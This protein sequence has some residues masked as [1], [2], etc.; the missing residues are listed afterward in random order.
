M[1]RVQTCI[2]I[3][4]F[5]FCSHFAKLAESIAVK[6]STGKTDESFQLKNYFPDFLWLLRDVTLIPTGV[7][8]KRV[9]PTDFLMTK[10]F[11]RSRKF[12]ESESDMVARAIMT[13]FPKITC[14][15]IQPP[16]SDPAVVQNIASRQDCLHPQFNE[17]VEQ[18]VQYLFEIVR[19]KKGVVAG[20][21]A[22]GPILAAMA[23]HYVEAVNKTDAI[24]CITDTWQ[25]AITMRCK[26]VME[27]LLKEYDQE[28]ERRIIEQG[29]PMEE[30]SQGKEDPTKPCTLFALHRSTLLQKTAALL[31]QVGHFLAAYAQSQDSSSA[32]D[33][34][35][36]C[37][38]LEI[39]AA[40]F[41]E[42][43]TEQVI[44][45]E[46][47]R[48]KVVMGGILLKYA[49]RNHSESRSSCNRLFTK[50]YGP[51]EEKMK[52]QSYTF[53]NLLKD[54]QV[55]QEKY[56]RQAVGPAKWEVYTEKRE[57]IKAQETGFKLLQGFKQ[58]AF[59]EAQKAADVKAAAVKLEE[60]VLTLQ[61]QVKND[62]EMNHK[63]IQELKE[64]HREEIEKLRKD[65]KERMER[66]R[67]RSEDFARA[68]MKQMA[69]ITNEHSK[70]VNEQ[71]D[72]MIEMMMTI[73]GQKE[74]A[75]DAQANN[76]QRMEAMMNQQAAATTAMQEFMMKSTSDRQKDFNE[77]A[78]HMKM[79]EDKKQPRAVPKPDSK[80]CPLL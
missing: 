16:S 39:G 3:P 33:K 51:I 34:D 50:L 31:E 60:S 38:E 28:M 36:L 6:D 20:K 13:F 75:L 58:K 11:C 15:T 56:Y 32:L 7:D 40:T 66:E 69:D 18:L 54:L 27:Q 25:T 63:R 41:T 52:H 2:S 29:L 9:S 8:G 44:H 68:Q 47:V 22:D 67:Q 77:L 24:P 80:F 45:G 30:D 61:M 59:D 64:H 55:L 62:A 71:S 1:N 70:Q 73:Y 79:M 37:A 12:K 46:L 53:E 48:K 42:E 23:T 57:Y 26:K 65:E 76:M 4:L 78:S 35:S 74:E 21:M 49:Q 17:Q 43:S 19:G 14:K 10:V 5:F 72:K